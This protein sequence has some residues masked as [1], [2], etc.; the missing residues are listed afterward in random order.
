MPPRERICATSV[1]DGERRGLSLRSPFMSRTRSPAHT[2][3]P[4]GS[5]TLREFSVH[6]RYAVAALYAST[7]VAGTRPRSL[8]VC[9]LARAHSRTAPHHRGRDHHTPRYATELGRHGAHEPAIRQWPARLRH[10]RTA[11][12]GRFCA[13]LGGQHASGHC[14]AER[15][16]QADWDPLAEARC[17][18]RSQLGRRKGPEAP[19]LPQGLD[20]LRRVRQSPSFH[21]Q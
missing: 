21:P 19:S 9:P 8:T 3:T 7:I 1:I 6:H 13:G 15:R 11:R 14:A 20:L 5:P 10:G 17:A 16:P 2:R 18:G 12:R 4:S